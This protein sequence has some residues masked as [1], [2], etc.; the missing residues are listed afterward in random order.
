MKDKRVIEIKSPKLRQIRN[1]LRNIIYQVVRS[2]R[3]RSYKEWR[4][5]LVNSG[6]TRRTIDDLSPE[7]LTQFRA[8]QNREN[9]ISSMI[10]KSILKCVACGKGDRDMAYN[11]AYDAWYCTTCFYRERAFAK[12]TIKKHRKGKAHED[13]AL[14]NHSKT[15]L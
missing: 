6:G 13:K 9:E 2:E 8:L 3:E 7:E 5:Y 1:T 14:V 11:K 4:K 15:F 10:D 12:E